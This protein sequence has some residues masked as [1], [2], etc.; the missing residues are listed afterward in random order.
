VKIGISV[1]RQSANHAIPSAINETG[2]FR[3]YHLEVQLTDK[4]KTLHDAIK[5]IA[6]DNPNLLLTN[7]QITQKYQ[8]R[9]GALTMLPTDFC[10]NLVNVGPDYETKFLIGIRRG[11]F[12][13]VD[14][15]WPAP[16]RPEKITWTPKGKDVPDDLKGET[17]TVGIYS[18]G[19]YSWNFSKLHEYLRFIISKKVSNTCPDGT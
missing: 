15:H 16:D 19:E 3:N 12:E 17:F 18:K 5:A 6:K 4:Q 11:E 14:F 8:I 10:Y 7:K 2:A 9:H 1:Y 13:F